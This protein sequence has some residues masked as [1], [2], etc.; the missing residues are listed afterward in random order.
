VPGQRDGRGP[1]LGTPHTPRRHTGGQHHGL[2]VGG[3]GQGL[4]GPLL[5]QQGNV[6][7]QR[8]R[9]FAQ[10][11]GNRR[12]ITPAIEHAN[13]LRALPGKNKCK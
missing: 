8:I 2:G 7:A 13:R 3:Q 11:V 6:F 5:D 1:A 4:L 12:V 10:G 9:G